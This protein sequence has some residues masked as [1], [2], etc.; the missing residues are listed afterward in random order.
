MSPEFK[1]YS[2]QTTANAV[3]LAD[4][5]MKNGYKL[6]TDGTENHLVLWDLRPCG[7]TGSK[8]E[9][10]CDMLHITLNKNAVF[11]DASALA[12]GG[13]VFFF[14]ILPNQIPPTACP[15]NKTDLF[16]DTITGAASARPR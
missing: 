14:C 5:L 11:G 2:K 15:Y 6:V 8:M 7:L 12:P 4:A 10:I 13:C 9:T 1:A 3:A 16:V